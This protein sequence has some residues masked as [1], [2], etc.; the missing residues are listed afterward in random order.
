M[1]E[2]AQDSFFFIKECS[3]QLYFCRHFVCNDL[4]NPHLN[5]QSQ[6]P[7]S[8]RSFCRLPF[9]FWFTSAVES[10]VDRFRFHWE[11]QR[12]RLRKK[13]D[14]TK[15][16]ELIGPSRDSSIDWLPRF[17][18]Q[19]APWLDIG[20]AN[21]ERPILFFLFFFFFFFVSELLCEPAIA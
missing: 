14:L 8:L 5:R 17:R 18:T 7:L 11:N 1:E 9:F 20:P 3:F 12:N 15:R 6:Y 19:G 2:T 13:T 21:R 4:Q 10:E 16:I